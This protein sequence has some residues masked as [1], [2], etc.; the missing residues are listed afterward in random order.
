MLLLLLLLFW[1]F[2][3]GSS[4][5]AGSGEF[6]VYRGI[7]RREFKRQEYLDKRALKVSFVDTRDF[8]N[9]S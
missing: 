1:L 3:L 4:A 8:A 7:R 9:K 2:F 5:G 6:H